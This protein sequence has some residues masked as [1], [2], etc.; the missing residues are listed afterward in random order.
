MPHLMA[1]EAPL[2]SL[3]HTLRHFSAHFCTLFR[4]R[5]SDSSSAL[6]PTLHRLSPATPPVALTGSPPHSRRHFSQT[7]PAL[8]PALFSQLFWRSWRLS[9]GSLSDSL[10][11][12]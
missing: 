1:T 3:Q 8:L 5:W 12:L 6:L 11:G 10:P 2:P 7:S 9:A 4:P